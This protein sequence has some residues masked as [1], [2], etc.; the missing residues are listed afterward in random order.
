[1]CISLK[2]EAFPQNCTVIKIIQGM[3]ST[4]FSISLDSF[5]GR[6]QTL[7]CTFKSTVISESTSQSVIR[8]HMRKTSNMKGTES[9]EVLEQA[10][11]DL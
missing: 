2:H 5:Y 4:C 8:K 1:M 11:S 3:Q 7:S 6:V 10:I 9:I